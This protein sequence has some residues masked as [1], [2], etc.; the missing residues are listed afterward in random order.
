MQQ[1]LN[2]RAPVFIGDTITATV[3]VTKVRQDKPIL[4]L[5]TECKNQENTVVIDGE[6]VLLAPK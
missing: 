5:A 2:F 1:T 4:T 3:T 6:A